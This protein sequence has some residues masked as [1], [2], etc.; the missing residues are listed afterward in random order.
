M[1]NTKKEHLIWSNDIYT[2]LGTDE[3]IKEQYKEICEIN[4]YPLEWFED[5]NKLMEFAYE[6]IDNLF[7]CEQENT[8][9]QEKKD[10]K[11]T[12]VILADVGRWDGRYAGGKTVFGIWEALTKIKGEEDGVKIYQDGAKL[13][14]DTYNH[15][16][17]SYFQIRELT[18]RGEKYLELHEDDMSDRE[19]HKKLFEDSHLSRNVTI[20]NEIY[21]W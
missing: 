2:Q 13:K 10:G 17:S 19:I 1:K 8:L 3:E 4:D 6:E 14:V 9:F 21:G 15:D 16:A 18:Q 12:Y 5:E 7:E 11:K 20:F